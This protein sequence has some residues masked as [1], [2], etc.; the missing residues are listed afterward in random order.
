[1]YDE[2]GADIIAVFPGINDLTEE[3][4]F[5]NDNLCTAVIGTLENKIPDFHDNS[6]ILDLKKENN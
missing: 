4:Q 5:D 3:G 1:M 2:I 6:I